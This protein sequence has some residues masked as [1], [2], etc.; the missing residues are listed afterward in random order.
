[1]GLGGMVSFEVNGGIEETNNFLSRIKVFTLAVSLGSVISL[2]EHPA[3]MSHQ[4]M[5]EEHRLKAGITDQLIRLSIGLENI[6][7]LTE[8]LEQALRRL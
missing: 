3:T 4:A 2:T 8:D 7:D 6:D 5:P 1:M